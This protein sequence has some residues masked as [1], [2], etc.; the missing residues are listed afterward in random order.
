[1]EKDLLIGDYLFVNKVAYGPKLPQTPLAVPFFHNNI[2]GT[3][4]RSYLKWFGMD[5]HRLPGYSDVERNDIV[6]FNYPAGDTALLGKNKR[7]DELQ[8]HNYHQFLRDEAFYLCN[9]SPEEFRFSDNFNSNSYVSPLERY[10]N[11]KIVPSSTLVN[12][13][14]S[15]QT[16]KLCLTP[17]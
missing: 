4:T 15:N 14:L 12:K 9:C 16:P 10:S 3:Y 6:V 2:P 5:Y 7:G 8:G 11:M 1:M 13:E 17:A